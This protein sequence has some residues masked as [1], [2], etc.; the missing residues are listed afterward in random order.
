M[1]SS[2]LLRCVGSD[3][4]VLEQPGVKSMLCCLTSSKNPSPYH[5]PQTSAL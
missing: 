4:E 3:R 1:P 5:Q 2:A